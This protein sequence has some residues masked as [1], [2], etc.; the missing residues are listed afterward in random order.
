MKL[1]IQP[2]SEPV[3]LADVK[4]QLGITDANSDALIVRRIIGARRW[5]ENYT[6]R[7]FITRTI[8]VRM[9]HFYERIELPF[10]PVA[11]IVSVK[12]VDDAGAIQ[13][14]APGNYVFD[15]YPMV[16]FV[17]PAF[18]V[19]WPTPRAEENAVRIQYVAGYGVA[20]D[21]PEEIREA[22]I[23]IVGNWINFQPQAENGLFMTRVPHAA[24]QLLDDYAIITL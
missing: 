19:S 22:I 4:T 12:Y 10:S 6:R 17:R 7:S 24:K 9:N 16:P 13:T 3:T 11:S 18:N 20:T 14:I 2:S 21:V 1:I 23:L 8:E 15:D 5:A